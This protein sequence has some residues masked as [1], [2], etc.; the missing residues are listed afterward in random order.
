[1]AQAKFVVFEG[2]DGSGKGTQVELVAERLR[3]EG[4]K[5]ALLDFPRYKHQSGFMVSKYLNGEY[6]TLDQIG[7]ELA[8]TFYAIDR[9]DAKKEALEALAENDYVL[10]NRYASSNM[11]FQASKLD[12]Y[13]KID[14]F[15]DW[16]YDLEFRIFGIPKPDLVVF[17]KISVETSPA[18]SQRKNSANTSRAAEIRTSTKPISISSEKPPKWPCTSLRALR[19]GRFWNAKR[20]GKSCL[21]RTLPTTSSPP[22]D[23]MRSNRAFTLAELLIGVTVS[24]IIMTGVAV[25]VGSG[26]ENSYRIR[27][28]LEE[29]RSSGNFDAVLGDVA[30]F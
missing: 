8:S 19:I 9:F 6:G 29:N 25:F 15:L 14:A 22:S 21:G 1:M 11:I 13:P 27:K 24:A 17:L 18:S 7:P 26:I 20:T 30:S 12:S 16:V 4:K 3:A 28:G 5:V 2:I 23:S 10:A